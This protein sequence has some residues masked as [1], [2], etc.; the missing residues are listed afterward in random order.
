MNG[1]PLPTLGAVREVAVPRDVRARSML[2]RIDYEDAFLV[3][4]RPAQDRSAEH[5]ARAI[6]EDAPLIMQATLRWGWSAIGFKL[7]SA[8]AERHVF[9]WELRRGAQDYVLLGADS[10]IGMPA[11]LLLRRQQ[12]TIVV[13]TFAELQNVIARALWAAV[14]P[15]HRRVVPFVLEQRVRSIRG[16]ARPRSRG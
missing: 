7:G 14:E 9:G 15:L 8:Q 11:E 10:R 1:R 13:A 6:L 5:W 2:P 16:E 3:E 4:T 12:R